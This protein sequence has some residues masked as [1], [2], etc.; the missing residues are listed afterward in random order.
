MI[1]LVTHITHNSPIIIFISIL[2]TLSTGIYGLVIICSC[3]FL[4]F[5]NFSFWWTRHWYIFIIF[6]IKKSC[7]PFPWSNFLASCFLLFA[8]FPLQLHNLVLKLGA[9]IRW[10]F[11]CQLF[12]LTWW[13]IVNIYF[14][15]VIYI[16][17][18]ITNF[19]LGSSEMFASS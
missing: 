10:I 13:L 8:P 2:A 9:Q 6:F 16:T 7:Y 18:A 14:T 11:H 3:N 4:N 19:S 15:I 5:L 12:F 17:I 1:C